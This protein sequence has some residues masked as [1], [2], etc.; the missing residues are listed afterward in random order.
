M[1]SALMLRSHLTHPYFESTQEIGKHFCTVSHGVGVLSEDVVQFAYR[2]TS[3]VGR[4]ANGT[5]PS[6]STP[7]SRLTVRSECRPLEATRSR[8]DQAGSRHRRLVIVGCYPREHLVA[9]NACRRRP[10]LYSA[11][12]LRGSCRD[13]V[14]SGE[15]RARIPKGEGRGETAGERERAKCKEATSARKWKP[16]NGNNQTNGSDIDPSA[17]APA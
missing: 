8:V 3:V 7:P 15:P 5:K 14:R 6:D 16:L 13:F 12:L 11:C 4:C 1:G 17:R 2:A 9:V 10:L